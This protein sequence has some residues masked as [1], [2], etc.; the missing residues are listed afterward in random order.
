MAEDEYW[1]ELYTYTWMPMNQGK[2]VQAR[3]DVMQLQRL[4]DI[5]FQ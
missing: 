4:S 5:S 1:N 3:R 2:P